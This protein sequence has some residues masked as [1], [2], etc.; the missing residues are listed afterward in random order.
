[1]N[2]CVHYCIVDGGDDSFVGWMDLGSGHGE[3]TGFFGG[4]PS[5]WLVLGGS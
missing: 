2:L 3:M 1:M 5:S 4:C